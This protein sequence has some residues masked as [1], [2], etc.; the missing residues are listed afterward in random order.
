MSRR[1]TR[2]DKRSTH[3]DNRSKK[4]TRKRNPPHHIQ[5]HKVVAPT[6]AFT[7]AMTGPTALAP[8]K[9]V[10]AAPEIEVQEQRP[11]Y[12]VPDLG[13]STFPEPIRFGRGSTGG[14]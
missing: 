7:T 2:Q 13:L 3:Q 10:L 12:V 14:H 4:S 9:E 8:G 5:S 6:M 1:R 11:G